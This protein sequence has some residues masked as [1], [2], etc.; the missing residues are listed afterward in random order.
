VVDRIEWFAVTI[1]ANTPA[2]APVTFPCVFQ[3]G[4][5]IEIDVKVPPGPSG[6]VGFFIGAGGSQ[7]IPYTNGAFIMPDD[8][9]FT[10]PIDNAINSGSFSVT[11][12]N[13]DAFDHTIQVGF[14]INELNYAQMAAVAA[15]G[16]SSAALPDTVTASSSAP[17]P[18][19]DPLSVDFLLAQAGITS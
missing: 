15:I 13:A 12:Y 16:T 6:N 19:I 3:Q 8:D 7:Y 1:P 10:W 2:N 9:Y 11:G 5:V 17:A 14:Q 18:A 4:S